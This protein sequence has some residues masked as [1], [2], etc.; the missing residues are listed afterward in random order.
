T[1]TETVE[2]EQQ[3]TLTIGDTDYVAHFPDASTLQMSTDIEGYEAQ[4]SEIERFDQ[5]NSGLSR[6]L[7]LSVLSSIMLA[8]M[9][10]IPSRY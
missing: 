4:V 10:F 7:V 6:V 1:E 9:A 5:Y 3:S 2:V 8:G